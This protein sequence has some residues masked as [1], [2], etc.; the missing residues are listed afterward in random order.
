MDAVLVEKLAFT[1]DRDKK[2]RLAWTYDADECR[3]LS[4]ATLETEPSPSP[5]PLPHRH[6]QPKLY[7]NRQLHLSLIAQPIPHLRPSSRPLTLFLALALQ[8]RP[9][10]HPCLTPLHRRPFVCRHPNPSLELEPPPY[11]PY[12]H[13]AG[14]SGGDTRKGKG[15][16]WRDAPLQARV[17]GHRRREQRAVNATGLAVLVGQGLR[18][19]RRDDVDQCACLACRHSALPDTPV[20]HCGPR[21]VG[22]PLA[23][24]F[25]RCLPAQNKVYAVAMCFALYYE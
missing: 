15:G 5:S 7:P 19:M 9:L 12:L 3:E 17:P 8:P 20:W 1:N 6:P 13:L 11:H 22:V 4:Q 16:L 23:E 2:G 18:H 10:P 24:P 21:P 25:A 14:H